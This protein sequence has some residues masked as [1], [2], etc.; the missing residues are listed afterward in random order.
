MTLCTH[1]LVSKNVLIFFL[2]FIFFQ[3]RLCILTEF[4]IPDSGSLGRLFQYFLYI[5]TERPKINTERPK[6]LLSDSHS[7][8]I[9][10]PHTKKSELRDSYLFQQRRKNEKILSHWYLV[11]LIIARPQG[12]FPE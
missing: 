3:E 11:D 6:G 1:I 8:L 9:G 7:V 4:E 10:N 5:S 12:D 2:S